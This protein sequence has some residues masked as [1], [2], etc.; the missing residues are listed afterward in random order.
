M[1][2]QKISTQR[3]V[4]T[5]L[6]IAIVLLQSIIPWL[7][8]IPINPMVRVTIIP[9]TVALGAMILGP[10]VGMLLGLVMGGLSFYHAWTIPMGIG[11]LMFRDPLVA[12]VP[13]MLVGLIIGWLYWQY[14]RQQHGT[15]RLVSMFMMGALTALINTVL[16]ITLTWIH[17]RVFNTTVAGLPNNVG[18]IWMFTSLAGANAL[19]E[20]FLDG[21][22][23]LLVGGPVLKVINKL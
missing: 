9:F 6:F 7:G 20:I 13:R 16:V 21:M 2:Q 11:A 10:K 19:L 5:A 4:L 17:F 3:L 14:V 23:G 15:K 8:F 22:L 1:N 18:I 12:F